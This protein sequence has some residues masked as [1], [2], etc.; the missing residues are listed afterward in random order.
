M[1]KSQPVEV[2]EVLSCVVNVVLLVL[3]IIQSIKYQQKRRGLYPLAKQPLDTTYILTLSIQIIA[4]CILISYCMNA[5]ISLAYSSGYPTGN[6]HKIAI[7]NSGLKRLLVLINLLTPPFYALFYVLRLYLAFEHTI[8]H[9]L[10]LTM[11]VYGIFISVIVISSIIAVILINDIDLNLDSGNTLG[12]ISYAISFIFSPIVILSVGYLFN[13]NLFYLV[14]QHSG[15]NFTRFEPNRNYNYVNTLPSRTGTIVT[16]TATTQTRTRTQTTNNMLK[17]SKVNGTGYNNLAASLLPHISESNDQDFDRLQMINYNYNSQLGQTSRAGTGS[18]NTVT[19][20]NANWN[21][22]SNINTLNNYGSNS[23]IITRPSKNSYQ[24]SFDLPPAASSERILL[25]MNDNSSGNL[26]GVG[27]NSSMNSNNNKNRDNV[28]GLEIEEIE[29]F[30]YG[31]PSVTP[32]I[33]TIND[34]KSVEFV[35]NDDT[36]TDADGTDDCVDNDVDSTDTQIQLL[37]V[38]IKQTL[39]VCIG[40]GVPLLYYIA[41]IL[42]WLDVT[43]SDEILKILYWYGVTMIIPITVSLSISFNRDMYRCLCYSCDRRYFSCC[44]NLAVKRS[45]SLYL[46]AVGSANQP[47]GRINSNENENM[48][49]ILYS[50]LGS[51]QSR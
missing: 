43:I 1:S 40:A 46:D 12:N 37:Q 4:I 41:C 14:L 49:D 31:T 23:N 11:I 21:T 45:R 39:L 38:I 6:N 20:E 42:I 5:S 17:K 19:F 8:Y 50:T 47:L 24:V 7:S 2:H 35:L 22:Y 15:M 3:F 33:R 32:S 29:K 30:I 25:A 48:D 13:K 16:A 44:V 27:N 9:I 26:L 10:N 28:N 51:V 18:I 36:S 34:A